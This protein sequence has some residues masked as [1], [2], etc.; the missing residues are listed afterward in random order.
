MTEIDRDSRLKEMILIG[1]PIVDIANELEIS[2]ST[3]YRRL[4]DPVFVLE[5][6][7]LQ[8]TRMEII[9]HELTAIAMKC[10]EQL[11]LILQDEETSHAI[12]LSAIKLILEM[13]SKY[14]KD[15]VL[16]KKINS[17]NKILNTRKEDSNG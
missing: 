11:N 3:I 9:N 14:R 5:V 1:K 8:L 16:E 2:E 6:N 7:E 12:K 10:M 15:V 4:R 17:L 13:S